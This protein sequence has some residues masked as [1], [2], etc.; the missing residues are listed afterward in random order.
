MPEFLGPLSVS[1]TIP[2]ISVSEGRQGAGKPRCRS[3]PRTKAWGHKK[4]Q[5]WHRKDSPGETKTKKYVQRHARSNKSAGINPEMAGG[6]SLM[7][8]KETPGQRKAQESTQGWQV[9]PL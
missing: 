5:G 1:P 7:H 6:S 9:G 8:R 3:C 2:R 4:Q